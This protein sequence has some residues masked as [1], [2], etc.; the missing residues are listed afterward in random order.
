ML[1]IEDLNGSWVASR[2]ETIVVYGET[3]LINGMPAGQGF[4]FEGDSIVGFTVYVL[5]DVKRG[6]L[7]NV[8]EILW[9][10]KFTEDDQQRWTRVDMEEVQRRNANTK[11]T[12][13]QTAAIAG[14]SAFAYLSDAEQVLK[15][16]S[17]IKEWCVGPLIKVKSCDI[18]PDVTNRAHTGLAVEHVHYIATCIRSEG[19]KD[20][21]SGCAD[22]HDVPVLVKERATSMLGRDAVEKWRQAIQ[23]QPPFPPF[24][25][26]GKDEVFCSL[27][28][29]HF[30]QA[31]NLFR[32][33]GRSL[34]SKGR[35]VVTDPSLQRALDEGINSIVLSSDIPVEE[36]CFV[37]EMLNKTHGR[38]WRVGEDGKVEIE[39]GEATQASQFVALSKVLDATELG[40]LVRIKMGVAEVDMTESGLHG[41]WHQLQQ[42]AEYIQSGDANK[43]GS[44][45]LNGRSGGHDIGCCGLRRWLGL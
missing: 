7:C 38:K 15:L 10:S 29:G 39:D 3:I 1:L 34:W 17:L 21:A 4:K 6:A 42:G 40:L 8:E 16:N 27:G 22:A 35:Y 43:H 45:N 26:D 30:S 18:C 5:K 31:L 41:D 37:A 9:Q 11:K 33:G 12:L 28:S 23:E 24:L 44:G 2:G 32:V 20:R 25:L 36:R 14:G 13:N 19:F